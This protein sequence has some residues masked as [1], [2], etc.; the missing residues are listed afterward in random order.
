MAVVVKPGTATPPGT[1]E[2]AQLLGVLQL[3][4]PLT[5]QGTCNEPVRDRMN[6]WLCPLALIP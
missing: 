4:P 5:P 3:P 2:T 1:L 6:A